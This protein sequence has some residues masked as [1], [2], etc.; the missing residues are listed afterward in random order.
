VLPS[1]QRR[2]VGRALL[3]RVLEHAV[4]SGVDEVVLSSWAF[5]ESAHEAFRRWGFT[6]RLIEF[7]L[8]QRQ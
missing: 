8:L 5:N 7:S 2:G 6:P 3:N 4:A 1:H